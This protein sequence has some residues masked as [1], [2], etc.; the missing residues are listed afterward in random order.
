M[1]IFNDKRDY[2]PED[3]GKYSECTDC[4]GTGIDE[5]E[6]ICSSCLGTGFIQDDDEPDWDNI[7]DQRNEAL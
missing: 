5:D 6:E 2:P 7:R 1:M 3:D 4:N